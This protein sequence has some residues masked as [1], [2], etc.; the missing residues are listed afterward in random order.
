MKSKFILKMHDYIHRPEGKRKYN[1]EMFGEIAPRYD[2]IAR[3]L[4]F[5]R[6]KPS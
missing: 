6:D 4:S 5:G 1:E 2:F 3:A